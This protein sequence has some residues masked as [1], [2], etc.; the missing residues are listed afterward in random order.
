[1]QKLVLKLIY[2]LSISLLCITL[3]CHKT[4][5]EKINEDPIPESLE[6]DI[7]EYL[8]NSDG[9]I[10][11]NL[12]L[13]ANIYNSKEELY[14]VFFTDLFNYIKV[15]RDRKGEQHLAR[16]GLHEPLDA[17]NLAKR[18]DG[19]ERGMPVVGLAFGKFFITQD[20]GGKFEDQKLTD[21]FVG[22]CL[23]NNQYVD[24]LKFMQIFFY[25]WRLE[26]GFTGPAREGKNPNGSDF[27]AEPSAS[28]VDTAKFFYFDQDD[29][30]LYFYKQNTIPMLYDH[31]PGL[32]NNDFER[33]IIFSYKSHENTSLVLPNEFNCYG[34]DFE[35]WYLSEAYEGEAIKTVSKFDAIK[36][37]NNLT[38]YGKFKRHDFENELMEIARVYHVSDPP[39]DY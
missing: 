5:S 32:I 3:V 8:I 22:Y 13:P 6:N 37:G 14:I 20:I 11:I 10:N 39:K 19:G 2:F 38:L 18:W 26:E 4:Y 1:M 15:L 9:L 16:Y 24:F 27:F 31:V 35:G 17:L 36:Y 25:Y 7:Y 23:N 33:N 28:I 29:L 30:P 21:S 34:Y 12:V